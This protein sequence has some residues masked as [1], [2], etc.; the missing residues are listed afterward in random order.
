MGV[1]KDKNQLSPEL[2]QRKSKLEWD[3]PS[4][5]GSAAPAPRERTLIFLRASERDELQ[6]G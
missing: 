4:S 1:G 2:W 3:S 6:L 5:S